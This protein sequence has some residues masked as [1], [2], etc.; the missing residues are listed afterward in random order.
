MNYRFFSLIKLILLIVALGLASFLAFGE[1]GKNIT[2]DQK[3]VFVLDINRTMNTKDVFSGTK[4]ISR[5]QAAKTLIQKT[6]LSDSQFSYGLILFNASAD[7]IIP[8][9]FDTGTFLLYLSGITTNLLQDGIKNFAQLNGI[10]RDQYTSYII[11]SDF[12]TILNSTIKL[13]KSTSLLGLGTLVGDK[14]RHFN[15][16]LDYDNGKPIFSARN[17]TFAKSLHA[18][19]STLTSIDSFSLQKLL[20]HGFALPLSQRIFLYAILGILVVLVVLL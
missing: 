2:P 19:Y 12:D 3:V 7:Y 10:L 13:P 17:D 6:I 15:G 4:Q 11:L 18:P 1:R 8:P 16:N 20:Y 9:T 5:I 14:V